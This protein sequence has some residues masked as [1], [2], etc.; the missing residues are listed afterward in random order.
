MTF[1]MPTRAFASRR[2]PANRQ[3]PGQAHASDHSSAHAATAPAKSIPFDFSSIPLFAPRS[4]APTGLAIG[5]AN[6]P[7]EQQADRTAAAVL[8]APEQTAVSSAS[9][10]A[11]PAAASTAIPAPPAARTALR[12][13]G[14]P[15]DA[16]TRA[17]F[18]P[19]FGRDFGQVRIHA[20]AQSA[21][22]ARDLQAQA[23]AFGQHIVFA[24][25]HFA[26]ASSAGR[27]LLAHELAHVAQSNGQP[28]Q[29]HRKP[30]PTWAGSFDTGLYNA[31]AGHDEDGAPVSGV[32]IKLNFS[33]HA[34]A[35]ADKIALV[36]IATSTVNG[37]LVPM[38]HGAMGQSTAWTPQDSSFHVDTSTPTP[39]YSQQP[40]AD[41]KL[42]SSTPIIGDF[43]DVDWK[44]KSITGTGFRKKSGK[45]F[46]PQ[47][48]WLYDQPTLTVPDRSSSSQHFET[49]AIATEGKQKGAFYGSVHWG[50]DK[51]AGVKLPKATELKAGANAIPGPAFQSAAK[52]WNAFQPPQ[53]G[54]VLPLQVDQFSSDATLFA[55]QDSASGKVKAGDE[56]T[57]LPHSS[58][59]GDSD[60]IVVSGPRQGNQETLPAAQV[61][62]KPPALHK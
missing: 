59:K 20:D 44:E 16:N 27:A 35:D 12:T 6:S 32:S 57:L 49:A 31:W 46:V 9:T 22:S 45:D 3:K 56:V 48:A 34:P 28:T 61:S 37:K 51:A 55:Q 8:R 54:N 30:L 5:A 15:L 43:T 47:D 58:A 26:P 2:A 25:R 29:I 19:R 14:Q 23:F 17:F 53:G 36:Q 4:S 60:V 42:S 21:A 41:A 62:S 10:P 40:G 38:N 1:A 52:A 33:P 7:L 18:E 50:Y 39:L 11:S 13:S 24:D